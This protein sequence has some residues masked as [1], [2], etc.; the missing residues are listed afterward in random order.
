MQEAISYPP[1]QQQGVS[2]PP[3]LKSKNQ[4][5][6]RPQDA[7]QDSARGLGRHQVQPLLLQMRTLRPRTGEALWAR[8]RQKPHLQPG[9]VGQILGTD[10][11]GG[12]GS[13]SQCHSPGPLWRP[14]VGGGDS[15]L[16]LFMSPTPDPFPEETPPSRVFT[17]TPVSWRWDPSIFNS[18]TEHPAHRKTQLVS[19]LRSGLLINEGEGLCWLRGC[20]APARSPGTF[21]RP[22]GP[23]EF[24]WPTGE[25]HPSTFIRGLEE[26]KLG[27]QG[28][29]GS[30]MTSEWQ[31]QKGASTEQSSGGVIIVSVPV[32]RPSQVQSKKAI[33][34]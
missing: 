15:L 1:T 11:W 9:K 34:K 19:S 31:T 27:G 10:T 32:E 6:H 22:S 26:W 21:S 25:G 18:C 14:G 2:F 33:L 3:A 13:P 4:R 5:P 12:G 7:L 8:R 30:Y 16:S 29:G 20:Q 17:V 24:T 28:D 23:G